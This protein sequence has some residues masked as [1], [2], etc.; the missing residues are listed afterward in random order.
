MKHGRNVRRI[1]RQRGNH[2]RGD[3]PVL[4]GMV[5]ASHDLFRVREAA[6]AKTHAGTVYEREY[7]DAIRFIKQHEIRWVPV[8]QGL[9]IMKHGPNKGD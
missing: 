8:T 9:L 3:L 4:P 5:V 7:L 2:E 6:V 1:R